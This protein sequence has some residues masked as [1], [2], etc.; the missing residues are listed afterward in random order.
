[1]TQKLGTGHCGPGREV[2]LVLHWA[3]QCPVQADTGKALASQPI[4]HTDQFGET[5]QEYT[6]RDYQGKCGSALSS[7]SPELGACMPMR[8]FATRS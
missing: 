7:S 5:I 8:R 1:M 4:N 3:L 6:L 2:A